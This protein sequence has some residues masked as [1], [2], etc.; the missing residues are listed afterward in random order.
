MTVPQVVVWDMGGIFQ[1]YFT[2][3][4]LELGEERGWAVEAMPLGPTGTVPD[5]E[6]DAMDAGELGE[7]EYYLRTMARLR[8]AGIDYDP[9]TDP[10]MAARRREE[11]WGLIEEIAAS[12]VRQAVLTNDASKWLGEDWWH[13]WPH[14]HLFDA[15][16][17]VEQVGVRKP[18]PEPFRHV[19][20]AL[21]ADPA[22]AVF[23]DDMRCNVRGAEAVGMTGHHFDIAR[24][25]ESVAT[26]RARL[27]LGSSR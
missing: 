14:R 23:V 17:D 12:P 25:E 8:E 4:I 10:E 26:L 13:T 5:P 16:V 7:G 22:D 21:D 11:V 19:L 1:R 6:Y 3:A 24:P 15:V 2:E 27:P 20:A 18:A 9:R